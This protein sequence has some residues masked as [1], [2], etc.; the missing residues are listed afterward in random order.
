MNVKFMAIEVNLL[1]SKASKFRSAKSS[2][3]GRDQKRTP[4][5]VRVRDN[6]FNLLRFGNV[7]ANLEFTLLSFFG[8]LIPPPTPVAA[9]ITNGI[10]CN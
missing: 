8:V 9:K 2:K 5:S 4:T 3:D 10:T 6:R 7:D 1:P